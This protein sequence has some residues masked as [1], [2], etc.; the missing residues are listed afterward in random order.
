MNAGIGGS[1][2]EAEL[3]AAENTNLAASASPITKSEHLARIKMVQDLMTAQ[4]IAAL[5]LDATTSL[6]YFTGMKAYQSERLLGAVIPADGDLFYIC[7]KFETETVKDKMKIE[8]QVFGWE[9]NE[10]PYQLLCDTLSK[11]CPPASKIALDD[12]T[13]F[14]VVDGLQKRQSGFDFV[15][16]ADLIHGLRRCKSDQEI[17]LMQTAKNLTLEVQKAAAR[18][19]YEGIPT[20]EVVKFIDDMHRKLGADNGSTFCIVLFGEATAYPHGV[21]YEQYLKPGDMV[22]IDTGCTIQG[23]HSD[24]TRSYCFGEPSDRQRE[25]WNLEKQAQLAAFD[26]AQIGNSCAHVDHMARKIIES[27]GL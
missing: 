20:A 5:Y 22:L 17:A 3:K 15:N 7:P 16:G 2:I 27:G 21:S 10:S 26:A 4:G 1:T 12:K 18:I 8:G 25:I 19:L 23:Y 11:I 14:F 6:A 24:I 13:P 9:E